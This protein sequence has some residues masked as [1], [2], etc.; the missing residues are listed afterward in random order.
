MAC[1]RPVVAGVRGEGR[2]IVAD[3][4]GGVAIEPGDARALADAIRTMKATPLAARQAMGRR[5]RAYVAANY[6][7]AKLADRYYRLL[8]A[9]AR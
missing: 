9:L 5:G 4:G 2:R 3:S 8:T 1:E 6:D 7:R